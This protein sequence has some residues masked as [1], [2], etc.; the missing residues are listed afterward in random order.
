VTDDDLL[1]VEGDYDK[2]LGMIQ[3]RCGDCTDQVMQWTNDWYSKREQ[4]EILA[5]H[6]TISRNQM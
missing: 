2:F 6:A 4:E 3:K 5:R 1:E